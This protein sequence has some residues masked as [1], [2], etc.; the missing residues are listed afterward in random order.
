MSAGKRRRA[1]S[2]VH[3]LV[4][5]PGAGVPQSCRNTLT[6]SIPLARKSCHVPR[7]AG[8]GAPEPAPRDNS[9]RRSPGSAGI[10]LFACE[11]QVRQLDRAPGVAVH[12]LGAFDQR[13][14]IGIDLLL[15]RQR[16]ASAD[17]RTRAR[18]AGPGIDDN[19]VYGL[20]GCYCC[21]ARTA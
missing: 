13:C 5:R 15:Q 17:D 10:A 16:T 21:R 9:D 3:A 6:P 11:F 4:V 19:I 14:A 2:V 12:K 1:A 20:T 8:G 7:R 18:P